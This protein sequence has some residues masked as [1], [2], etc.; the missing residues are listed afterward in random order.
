MP[1]WFVTGKLGSGKSLVAVGKIQEYLQQ[2]RPIVTNINLFLEHLIVPTNKTAVVYRVPDKPSVEDLEA[3]P[4][5]YDGDYDE[6]KNGL[7]VLDELATWLNSRSFGE[8]G[9]LALI[10]HLVML[11]KRGWDLMFLVQNVS[12]ID[13]QVR[14][15]LAELVVHCRRMDRLTIPFLSTF[16]RLGGFEIRP[17]KVHWGLVKYGASDSSPVVERWVYSGTNLYDAYDTRQVYTPDSC[18]LCRMLPPYYFYGVNV[19][20]WTHQKAGFIRSFNR[21]FGSIKGRGAFFAG[22]LV[23]F[24]AMSILGDDSVAVAADAPATQEAVKPVPVHP[25]DGVR[26]TGSVKGTR[27]FDYI[28]ETDSGAFYPDNLGYR[29]RWIS[30]CRAALVSGNK[31]DYVTCAPYRAYSEAQP[32]EG[33][34]RSDGEIDSNGKLLTF[35]D[36]PTRNA[37][38]QPTET[39]WSD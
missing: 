11:R 32:R 29:V 39:E 36:T 28:F 7:L 5:A 19:N 31:T 38:P 9:R 33:A 37:S 20:G 16:T 6:N 3:V 26:I 12:M 4:P 30:D 1:S 21:F 27:S 25:L 8:K 23:C 18:G 2:G 24:I 13:S 22:L 34:G 10:H 15:G 17:P 35:N 14:E